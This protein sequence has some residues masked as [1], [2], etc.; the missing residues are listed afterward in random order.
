MKRFAIAAILVAGCSKSAVEKRCDAMLDRLDS[1]GDKRLGMAMRL[2]AS[3][4]CTT[5]LGYDDPHDKTSL[6]AEARHALDECT[7]ETACEPLRA[8][9]AKHACTWTL[10]SPTDTQPQFSC[11]H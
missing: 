4:Y 7:A 11:W 6:A 2:S 3:E 10:T 1:C 8:C 5:T 9:L